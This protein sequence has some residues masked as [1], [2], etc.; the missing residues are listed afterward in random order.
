MKERTK[1]ITEFFLS[2]DCYEHLVGTIQTV[3]VTETAYDGVSLVGH[4]K[5]Y[6]QV[7][8]FQYKIKQIQ[9][10]SFYMERINLF[11]HCSRD[12]IKRTKSKAM[13]LSSHNV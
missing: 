11:L 8:V 9:L 13:F 1:R 7:L 12:P 4:T 6:E 10:V 5:R 2:Y 3:L